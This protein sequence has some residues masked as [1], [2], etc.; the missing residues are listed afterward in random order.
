MGEVLTIT[1]LLVSTSLLCLIHYY[2][3]LL[4][5]RELESKKFLEVQAESQASQQVVPILDKLSREEDW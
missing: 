3:Y 5:L 2:V 4:I 1:V